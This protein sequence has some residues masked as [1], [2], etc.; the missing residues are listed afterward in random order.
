ML[1]RAS[2]LL[3]FACCLVAQTPQ[4]SL[5]TVP[6]NSGPTGRVDSPLAFDPI[7]N[8]LLA[9][10]GQDS[11][12]DRNDLWSFSLTNQ[13]WTQLQPTGTLP[14]PRH[15]HTLVFDPVRRRVVTFAG[16]AGGFFSDVWAYDIATNA[17]LKLAAD[18]A[19]PSSRYGH[20]A[21]Y[22]PK[23]ERMVISHGFTTQGRFDDT[24]AF[25][26]KSNS[27]QDLNPRGSRPLKRCLQHAAIDET[28]GIMYLFGGCASGFGPCPLDDLW[29]LDLTTNVWQEMG[30]SPRP[31]G[32]THNGLA[33]DAARRRLVVYGGAGSAGLLNDYWEFDPATRNWS[34][35]AIS[36]MATARSRH[37]GVYAAG[38]IYFF[39]GSN[40][41]DLLRLRTLGPRISSVRNAFSAA[42]G[43]V[44]PGAVIA[45]YG[46]DLGPATGVAASL[47][48]GRLPTT[49]GSI[50]VTVNGLSSPLFYSQSGQIN[51]Q[52]PYEVQGTTATLQVRSGTTLMA[53][54]ML[55]LAPTAPGLFTG[56]FGP[57]FVPN[58]NDAPASPGSVIVLFATG[59]G[60]TLPPQRTGQVA[61]FS[62]STVPTAT[63]Q[64]N[65]G[66][67]AAALLYAGP[68]PGAVGV[69]QI[70]AQLP[71]GVEK[72]NAVPV[73]LSVGGT[74]SSSV[75]IVIR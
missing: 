72:G 54:T 14:A 36:N 5:S 13:Q 10:G 75:P 6:V 40:L 9:F 45:L 35:P 64:L 25:S 30:S 27:W 24:W 2:F 56:V 60:Q 49:L 39:G 32:R 28:G 19:G 21:V 62:L 57:T 7:G 48:E 29:A 59:H 50:S 38:D 31:A 55:P 41:P 33:F 18:G 71:A 70:N 16:Q 67:A 73:T 44:A 68:L 15:G 63:V 74:A 51:L 12:G 37:Q 58:S 61:D 22:D 69:M 52:I 26:L 43:P 23:T 66:S 3:T 1:L 4:L 8:Q 65:V 47:S 20:S 53:S 17:W 11:S 34:S 42:E 46:E